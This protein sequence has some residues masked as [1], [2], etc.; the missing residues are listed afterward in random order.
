MALDVATT[1]EAPLDIIFE[2]E[3]TRDVQSAPVHTARPPRPPLRHKPPRNP[4]GKFLYIRSSDLHAPYD[5]NYVQTY[6]LRCPECLRQSFTSLQGL[7]N[8]A[9]IS[10]G[11]EWGTHDE[12]VRACAVVEPDLDVEMGIEVGLG[13]NGILP[14]IRSLFKM[15]VGAHQ[16]S[17]SMLDGDVETA[18]AGSRL[19]SNSQS[20]NLVKTLGLHEDTPALAPFLGKEALR[21]SIKVL[22][23]ENDL[24]DVDGFDDDGHF[25]NGA[26]V[27]SVPRVVSSHLSRPWRMRYIHR[28]DFEP[29][30]E[31]GTIQ[32]FSMNSSSSLPISRETSEQDKP[33]GNV[34]RSEGLQNDLVGSTGSRFHFQ[35]RIS[36]IDRSLWIPPG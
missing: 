17:E 28:N 13:P 14:G 22:G 21:R 25:P 3:L 11:T 12:C 29:E 10:H 24:V 19:E 32:D 16:V 18:V 35:A 30:R 7:L 4:N 34:P 6:L 15:A 27:S 33:N 1:I 9:R 26:E 2:R 20:S 23:N 5:E 8:H 31:E 36:I